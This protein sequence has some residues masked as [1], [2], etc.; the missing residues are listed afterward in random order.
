MLSSR[1]QLVAGA[2][3]AAQGALPSVRPGWLELELE[4]V[5]AITAA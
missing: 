5:A 3:F 4:P 1:Q 2:F